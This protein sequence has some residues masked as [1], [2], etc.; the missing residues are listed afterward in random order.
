MGFP[1]LTVTETATGI[2]VRQDRFLETGIAEAKDNETLWFVHT[3]DRTIFDLTP[4]AGV[5]L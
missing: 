4:N 2:K 1:V 5:F 3:T